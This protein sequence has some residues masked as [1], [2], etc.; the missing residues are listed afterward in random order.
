MNVGFL[1]NK[2]MFRFM[3]VNDTFYNISVISYRSVLLVEET[4]VRECP[5]KT[6]DIPQV[7]DKLYHILLYRVRLAMKGVRT[8]NI[9]GDRH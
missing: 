7:T 9:S 1:I 5:E 3:V 6:N 8:H 4:R 2:V